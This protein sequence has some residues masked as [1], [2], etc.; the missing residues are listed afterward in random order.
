MAL[1]DLARGTPQGG[2]QPW[3]WGVPVREGVV[4]PGC[5]DPPRAPLGLHRLWGKKV[6]SEAR[7][8]LT[9]GGLGAGVRAGTTPGKASRLL[10]QQ[11][12]SQQPGSAEGHLTTYSKN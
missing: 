7:S 9:R 6:M 10:R 3:G 8:V 5:F 2:P 11:K 1:G 12:P 4:K